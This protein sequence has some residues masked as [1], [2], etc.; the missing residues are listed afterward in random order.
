MR[1]LAYSKINLSL[2]VWAKQG[3]FHPIDSVVVSVDCCDTVRVSKRRDKTVVVKGCPDVAQEQNSAYK[4]ACEFVRVF[5]VGGCNVKIRKRIPVGAGMG[6][7]SAD[8]VSVVRCLCKL[9]GIDANCQKVRLLC[10]QLGSDNNFLLHGGLARM[11]GKGDDLQFGKLRKPLFF[12]VTTFSVSLLAK[13]VYNAFDAVGG[14]VRCDNDRLMVLLQNGEDPSEQ[15]GNNLQQSALSISNFA[16]P[17]LKFCSKNNL[18]CHMT[19]SGSAFFVAFQNKKQAI[20]A[21]KT[22]CS[23]GFSTFVCKTAGKNLI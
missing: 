16:E 8:A 1:D 15:F 17:Y 10:S 5:G 13:D 9:Y 4:A 11:T 23:A 2:N 7:S 12:V 18:A 20:R 14:N 3:D 21:K 22:L 6:G 19:G